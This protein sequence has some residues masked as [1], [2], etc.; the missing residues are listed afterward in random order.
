MKMIQ[1]LGTSSDSGKSTLA[2]AF[3]R[4]L[5]DLGYRVSPFKAVNMSLNS[6]AIKDGSEIARAQW[7][8]AMA[9]GAEPSAYM[10]PVLL[11][12]EGHHKSQVI[13][14]GRSIGSMG[15]ND[16]YNYINKNAKII[17]ESID[18]LSNKYDV[19]ISEGAGSPAEINLAGRDFANIYVSSLY[20]TPAILVADIDRGGVFASIYGTINLMQRS[21]LL[22]YYIINKMRGDQSLLY[23]GIERIEELTGK[24]CLGIVPYIDLKLPGEDSLDYNFSGS[25]S[26]GIVRYPY[27]ENYSDFDPLI[28]NEKAFYIKNKEDLKRC[29]VIILPGSKDVFHDLEY[30]NSN[31]IADSIKRCSGEKMIIG[32]CGGY[33]MLGKRIND[34]S[35]V[36]SDGVSIPG[37]GLLDI[38]TYYNKTKTTG[39]VKY[40]FAENQ[41]KINGSGT[42]YEI[43]YGSIVKNNEMPL[44]ITDHGPE[45]SVSSNG[46]VIGTNVH[47]ILENNEFYRYITGEYLDYDNIIENSIETLAGI[48][49][50]SINIE[51]FLELLN[52]A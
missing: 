27:M 17:K 12:P 34:A 33:Q 18:F 28:F 30:I 32:I 2:T 9:A 35:G 13:I 42:G 25:G 36:E 51:G 16:Y 22:K 52:D 43:H 5:K 7:V 10:N 45:G 31:G 47:G 41:L 3:C 39:S 50:K 48:V 26:I 20:N 1:V 8:Q 24:K 38:E 15:I 40:R 46:M 11:K 4:I 49:K 44:L 19:I 23:P 6:I 37:L 14:L 29:D 21:D